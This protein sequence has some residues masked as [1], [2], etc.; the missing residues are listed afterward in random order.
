MTKIQA[1]TGEIIWRFG[2]G[3]G[4]QL[5]FVDDPKGSFER[6]H[7]LRVVEPGVIQL[8]DN[9]DAAPSRLVRYRIDEQALTATLVLE[10]IDAPT[11]YTPVGGGTDVLA[12]GGAL[13][14]FGRAGRVLESSAAGERTWEL[15]GIDGLYVFRAQRIPSLYS[16]ERD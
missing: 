6:Q 16:S 4:N 2:G 7:G 15:T 9:G 12:G 1:E 14:S 13:V 8:L 5:T 11:T 3:Q 10:V